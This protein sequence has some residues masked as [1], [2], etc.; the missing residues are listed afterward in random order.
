MKYPN[1]R[2][3]TKFYGN[4]DAKKKAYRRGWFTVGKRLAEQRAKKKVK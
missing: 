3:L 2:H 4:N 1:E